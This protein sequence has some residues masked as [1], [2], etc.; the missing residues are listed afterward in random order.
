MKS[1]VSLFNGFRDEAVTAV[2]EQCRKL[3][4]SSC[5]KRHLKLD[6][7]MADVLTMKRVYQ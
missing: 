2:V 3:D 5:L 7:H 4:N 6:V 1:S